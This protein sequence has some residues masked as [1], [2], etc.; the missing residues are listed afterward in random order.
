MINYE[1]YIGKTINHLTIKRL[2]SVKTTT[3]NIV[4]AECLCCCGAIAH[5]R[6]TTVKRGIEKDCGCKFR[7]KQRRR[8]IERNTT[9][10]MGDLKNKLYR[11]WC[12]MKS[13][14]NTKNHLSYA[15][16]GGRGIKVCEEWLDYTNFKNWAETHGYREDLTI[17]RIDVNGDYSPQNCRWA[18]RQDQCNNKR[19]NVFIEAFGDSK[20]LAEWARDERCNCSAENISYRIKRGWIPEK[21]I[22][23]PV[24]SKDRYAAKQYHKVS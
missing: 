22:S 20:T 5:K 6:L 21:A 7:E 13:R 2:Y 15:N 17:D 18:S 10:G 1:E 4:Y 8:C 12:G 14:C 3:Q 19:S 23:I 24:L 9:H 11:T 16:Y